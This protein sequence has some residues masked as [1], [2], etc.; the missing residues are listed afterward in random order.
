[1]SG[2]PPRYDL[3]SLNVFRVVA[4]ERNVTRAARLCHLAV[5]AVSKR[6]SELEDQ[7]GVPLFIRH[8][9]GMGLTPAGETMLHYVERVHGDLRL[10]QL[11]LNEH[12]SG[13]TGH[14]RLQAITSA[15]T[16]HLTPDLASFM[17]L[18]PRVDFDI[19]E[20]VGGSI[21]QAVAEGR[22]DVGIVAAD[23]AALDLETFAYR[24]ERLVV[25]AAADHPLAGRDR[26]SFA[27]TL[28]HE[29]I[30]P[31]VESSM[32][33][34][35]SRQAAL[36]QRSIRQRVRISS[37]EAMCRLAAIRLGL[38]VLPESIVRPYL[39][40][41]KLAA[42]ELD[43]AWAS[44]AIVVVVRRYSALSPVAKAFVGHLRP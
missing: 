24:R 25:I 20:R 9:R 21:V 12:G 31:H 41:M 32:N 22:A 34:L 43:E 38:C 36:L 10:M 37:F 18:Y 5:S 27:E 40:P 14:I 11:E 39:K 7:V 42:L 4:Q 23:T 17:G 35:L 16:N 8:A 44:R 1:M 30:G 2:S 29:F 13:A 6:I 33:A 15:L 26:V 3:V 28:D 19:E